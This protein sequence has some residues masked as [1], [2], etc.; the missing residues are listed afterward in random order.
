VVGDVGAVDVNPLLIVVE[1]Y[2]VLPTSQCRDLVINKGTQGR[3]RWV[4][5]LD[6][7]EASLEV[8]LVDILLRGNS[9]R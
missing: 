8:N 7:L 6:P 3:D 2:P 9:F 4:E 1:G 5:L